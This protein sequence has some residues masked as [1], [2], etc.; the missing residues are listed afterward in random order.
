MSGPYVIDIAAMYDDK[1]LCQ[2]LGLK[3]GSLDRA[4]RTGELRFT[5]RGGKTLYL[6]EWVKTWLTREA[7]PACA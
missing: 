1:T 7:E 4:R 5:R 3:S 6:G 2:A